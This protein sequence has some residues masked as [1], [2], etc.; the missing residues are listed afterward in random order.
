MTSQHYDLA[1]LGSDPFALFLAALL[2]EDHSRKVILIH[3]PA[4]RRRLARRFDAAAGAYARPGMWRLLTEGATES[5][6]RLRTAKAQGGLT[7]LDIALRLGDKAALGHVQALA[8]TVRKA[9]EPL[10]GVPAD[11]AGNHQAGLIFRDV[12]FVDRLAMRSRMDDWHQRLG[13]EQLSLG[14]VDSINF[15]R[16]GGV[17][18]ARGEDR[19]TSD[20]AV[21][22]GGAMMLRHASPEDTSQA[23]RKQVFTAYL[24]EP[25]AV[26]LPQQIPV[27]L[28]DRIALQQRPDLAIACVVRGDRE[29]AARTLL[30]AMPGLAELKIAGR[31]RFERLV[32]A[33]AAPIAGKGRAIRHWLLAG[34]GTGAFFLAP[35]LARLIAGEA[36]DIEQEFWRARTPFRDPFTSTVAEIGALWD[37]EATV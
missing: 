32:T 6:K 36:S 25:G 35:S 24:L 31:G 20:D 22:A 9:A 7:R 33:D 34:L 4:N 2:H 11:F 1:V 29:E 5:R 17:R 28:D 26:R 37:S 10:V 18:I 15:V 30:D 12:D 19:I 13:L 23:L 3:N 27:W 8:E 21:L 16:D 14:T